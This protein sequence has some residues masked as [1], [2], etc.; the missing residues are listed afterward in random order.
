MFG[1]LP[2]FLNGLI[3]G[4]VYGLTALGLSLIFG[5]LR[6]VNIAHGSFVMVGAYIAY[7]AFMLWG[8]PPYAA[9]AIAAAVGGVVGLAL[10]YAV[11]KP[12]VRAG[13]MQNLVAMFALGVLLAELARILWTSNY[14]G[15]VWDVGSI[16]VAGLEIPLSKLFG[17]AAALAIALSFQWFLAKT[18]LG[19]AMRA[20]VQDAVGAEIVGINVDRIFAL[21]F[22]L[23]IA[24]TTM[25]G[26]LATLFIP[27]GINPYMG[28]EYTLAAFVIAVLG[29]LGSTMGS[30]IAGLI[31]GVIQSTGYYAFSAAGFPQP[32]AM[33]LFVD[34][35]VLIIVLLIKPTGLFGR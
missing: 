33:A 21:S 9:L 3:I 31:F 17:A 5:V 28:G 2:Y 16:A 34:F 25:G 6:V 27:V 18:Y 22:A 8:M 14:V 19:R 32:Y 10:Y 1:V 20:V 7:F 4:S 26:V 12:T 24:I 35:L 29:G 15:Y 30:Y 11:V 23:G 13:E